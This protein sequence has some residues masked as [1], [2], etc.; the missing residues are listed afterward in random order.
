MKVNG[1]TLYWYPGFQKQILDA[2]RT[3]QTIKEKQPSSLNSNAH[4]KLL[5]RVLEVILIE[6]P[7]DPNH[8]NFAQGNT[9]GEANRH[10]RR[11]KFL[12][13]FRLFFRFSSERKII[14]Y[15]WVNDENTLRQAG[16]RS[17]PYAIFARR[18]KS[19][20]PPSDWNSLLAESSA[21]ESLDDPFDQQS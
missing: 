8:P 2:V 1:W 17:D 12:Q 6:I 4:A 19:G 18:L 15:A 21:I 13:R 10:W 7:S 11:A 5:K 14:I 20:D 3:V 16:A 9:L